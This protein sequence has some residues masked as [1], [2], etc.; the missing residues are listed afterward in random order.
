[1]AN[2]IEWDGFTVRGNANGPGIYTGPTFS[3]H[4]VVNNVVKDNVFGLYLNSSAKFQNLVRHNRF[5]ANNLSGSANGN[6]IYSDQ[7]V[8]RAL[9]TANKFEN[10]DNAAAL[11]ADAPTTT[12][13]VTIERNQSV[14][15]YS[16]LGLFNS[17]NT[18]VASNTISNDRDDTGSAIFVGDDNDG[19]LVERNTISSA[20]YS[21]IAVRGTGSTA[22]TNVDVVNNSV[23]GA[24]NNGIDVTADGVGAVEVRGNTVKKS[25]RSGLYFGDGTKGNLI[26][27]NTARDNGALDCE[28]ASRANPATDAVVGTAGT[29]NTWI[30]NTGRR[31]APDGLCST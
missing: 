4:E 24:Y 21:G 13:Q 14:D 18:A 10:H 15:D 26:L 8:Q 28:D 27:D 11:F 2:G 5:T 16:F 1:V 6:G 9:V 29:A 22:P 31:D 7:G 20:G 30:D 12:R 3:G 17:S 25:R 19:V 23:R